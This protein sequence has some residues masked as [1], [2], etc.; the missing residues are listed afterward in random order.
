MPRPQPWLPPKWKS[1]TTPADHP[2]PQMHTVRPERQ[3]QGPGDPLHESPH[4]VHLRTRV[5]CGVAKPRNSYSYCCVLR[6]AAPPDPQRTLTARFV[7]R[8]PSVL[9]W[10]FI[11][12]TNFQ[13]RT[14]GPANIAKPGSMPGFFLY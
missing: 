4:R 1:P 5:V 13:L 7:Q 3:L 14:P 10:K 2:S 8:I 6:L 9:S 11:S 12:S